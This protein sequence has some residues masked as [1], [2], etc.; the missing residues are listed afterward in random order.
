MWGL[1]T[2]PG[3]QDRRVQRH[4]QSADQSPE[5]LGEPW[6]TSSMETTQAQ[7]PTNSVPT[8]DEALR[9]L[10]LRSRKARTKVSAHVDQ[11]HVQPG[12]RVMTKNAA[13]NATIACVSGTATLTDDTGQTF[14]LEAP[15][16]LGPWAAD[17]RR[18]S[19]VT[20][21]TVSSTSFIVI[22]CRVHDLVESQVPM[23]RRLSRKTQ[24]VVA[25]QTAVNEVLPTPQAQIVYTFGYPALVF[26]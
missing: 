6:P 4:D 17:D 18:I 22:D 13:A 5:R 3:T 9:Q 26:A 25:P 16:V 10:G 19:Q 21:D 23:L 11:V 7:T 2:S 24:H 20:V 1:C 14:Q 15:F 8:K 12:R